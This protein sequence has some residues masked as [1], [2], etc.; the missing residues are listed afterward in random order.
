MTITFC[1]LVSR[2]GFVGLTGNHD[3][4]LVNV[5]PNQPEPT[6]AVMIG[7]VLV[8]VLVLVIDGLDQIVPPSVVAIDRYGDALKEARQSA[9]NSAAMGPAG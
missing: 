3:V 8:L 5:L 1:A 2:A 6:A 4:V 7:V 9:S